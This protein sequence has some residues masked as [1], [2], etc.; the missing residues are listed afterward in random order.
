MPVRWLP[1]HF[2]GGDQKVPIDL[3]L[4]RRLVE[5]RVVI[6]FL[7]KTWFVWWVL[8]TLVVLRWFQIFSSPADESTLEIDASSE[9]QASCQIPSGA[10]GRLF[11]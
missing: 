4:Y 3:P 8:S 7:E 1:L 9:E 10:A 5:E 11:T 2:R 6:P